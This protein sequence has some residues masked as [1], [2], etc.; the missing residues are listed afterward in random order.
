MRRNETLDVL[1]IPACIAVVLCHV[2]FPTRNMRYILAVCRYAVPFF[3]MVTGWFLWRED[4]E[5]GRQATLRALRTTVRMILM[6]SLISL[7]CTMLGNVVKGKPFEVWLHH[8]WN[9]EFLLGFLLYNRATFLSSVG[10]YLFA[11]LYAQLLYLLSFSLRTRPLLCALSP[12]LLA[13]GIYRVVVLRLDWS[14]TGNWLFTALPFLVLGTL[15][16]QKGWCSR[17]PVPAAFGTVALGLGLTLYEA[18]MYG[19]RF[20]T[21]G[22]VLLA[23]GLFAL[24]VRGEGLHWPTPLVRFGREA[25]PVIFLLHCSMQDLI[26]AYIGKPKGRLAW[27]MPA[28]IFSAC[29]LI[30]LLLMAARAQLRRGG[31]KKETGEGQQGMGT[32]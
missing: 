16:R 31:V 14:F 1:R 5:R 8:Y 13:A 30:A 23:L 3:Y 12:V 24:A 6:L 20:L 26:H 2:R 15:L 10:W 18:S 28:L 7:P 25:T 9:R 11:L 19:Q 32:Q 27:A 4:E 21:V 29:S 17:I 22:V